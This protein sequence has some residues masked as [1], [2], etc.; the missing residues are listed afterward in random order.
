MKKQ[1]LPPH[2]AGFALVG[3]PFDFTWSIVLFKLLSLGLI[4]KMPFHPIIYSNIA[5]IDKL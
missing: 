5:F 2:G 3:M 1:T 4:T